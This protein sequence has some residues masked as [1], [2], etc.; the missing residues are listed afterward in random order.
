MD[1]DPNKV[2]TAVAALLPASKLHE[3]FINASKAILLFDLTETVQ[4]ASLNSARIPTFIEHF[5]HSAITINL[6]I[7]VGQPDAAALKS[8]A[9]SASIGSS[10]STYVSTYVSAYVSLSFLYIF[11]MDIYSKISV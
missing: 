10:S 7:L 9:T 4:R 8:S 3:I 2:T 6:E 11:Y 1:E 5:Y